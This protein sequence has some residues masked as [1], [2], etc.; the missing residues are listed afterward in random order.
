MYD[1]AILENV[2]ATLSFI[3]RSPSARL[4]FV[5]PHKVIL[6]G[7]DARKLVFGLAARQTDFPTSVPYHPRASDNVGLV[8]EDH[9]IRHRPLLQSDIAVPERDCPAITTA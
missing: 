1:A 8:R 9:R 5:S 7:V 3:C 6:R 2:P 4:S